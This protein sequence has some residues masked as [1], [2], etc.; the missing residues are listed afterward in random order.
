MGVTD[1]ADGSGEAEACAPLR[2]EGLAARGCV[3]FLF[4]VEDEGCAAA[5]EAATGEEAGI[6][7]AVTIFGR[8]LA[9]GDGPA[10]DDAAN[11]PTVIAASSPNVVAMSL[12]VRRISVS[13]L[14]S[15]VY[16]R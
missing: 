7:R 11:A 8:S 16:C 10:C 2:G 3:A 9:R 15:A 5:G 14:T 13:I 1:G 4:D 6:E 12:T